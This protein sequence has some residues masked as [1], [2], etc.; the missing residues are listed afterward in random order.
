MS[1]P[2][3]AG[4]ETYQ[5]STFSQQPAAFEATDVERRRRQQQQQERTWNLFG[6]YKEATNDSANSTASTSG[7]ETGLSGSSLAG[8]V[9]GD[10][11]SGL[12]ELAGEGGQLGQTL[13]GA[14]LSPSRA[15]S[16][17][18]AEVEADV[19]RANSNQLTSDKTIRTMNS[20]YDVP[21]K[22]NTNT[23]RG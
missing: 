12:S 11:R 15:E 5:M 13:V 19:E 17:G 21:F 4:V 20:Q 6:L 18:L 23:G 1:R 22:F 10:C 7:C 14:G 2:V 9:N 16:M 8:Q 3:G